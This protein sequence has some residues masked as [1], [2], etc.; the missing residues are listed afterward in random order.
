[1]QIKHPLKP[2]HTKHRISP[3][4]FALEI[5]IKPINGLQ[6]M[7]LPV[8][9]GGQSHQFGVT[10][11]MFLPTPQLV[12]GKKRNSQGQHVASGRETGIN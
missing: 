11:S 10:A 9:N 4:I 5:F 12:P 6:M 8:Q 1:M 7:S 2:F 3:E